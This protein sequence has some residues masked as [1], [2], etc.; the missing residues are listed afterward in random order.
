MYVYYKNSPLSIIAGT[1]EQILVNT[2]MSTNT[3]SAL[4][5]LNTLLYILFYTLYFTSKYASQFIS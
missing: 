5:H 1:G 3:V 2:I 4:A